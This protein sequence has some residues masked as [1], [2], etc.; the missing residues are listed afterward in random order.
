MLSWLIRE[1]RAQYYVLCTDYVLCTQ[2][3]VLSTSI[4]P[5]SP[6]APWKAKQI[7]ALRL[8]IRRAVWQW[9]FQNRAVSKSQRFR[10]DCQLNCHQPSSS[11]FL[12]TYSDHPPAAS[13]TEVP[14]ADQLP[15]FGPLPN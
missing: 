13:L 6:A 4:P 7:V 3:C 15:Q 14:I 5:L 10:I 9:A 12:A 1:L 2:H 11:R 8:T